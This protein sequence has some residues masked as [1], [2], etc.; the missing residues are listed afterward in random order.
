MLTIDVG[1]D[2]Q[3]NSFIWGCVL[4]LKG[5]EVKFFIQRHVYLRHPFWGFSPTSSLSYQRIQKLSRI[6]LSAK[7]PH[8]FL[9]VHFNNGPNDEVPY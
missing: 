6:Q 7:G 8:T 3:C 2:W 9:F 1:P 5:L 4:Q